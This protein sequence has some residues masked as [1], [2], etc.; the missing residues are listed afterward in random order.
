MINRA[1]Q[2]QAQQRP[3]KKAAI[4]N[5]LARISEIRGL[6]LAFRIQSGFSMVDLHPEPLRLLEDAIPTLRPHSQPGTQ[7]QQQDH[8]PAH[9]L[10]RGP[11]H[12]EAGGLPPGATLGA[13][14]LSRNLSSPA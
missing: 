7:E 8:P 14:A 3:D 4:G 5:A 10:T 1:I 6:V 12:L 11:L 13:D 9:E 2:A